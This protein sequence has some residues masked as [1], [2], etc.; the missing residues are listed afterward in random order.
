MLNN[1]SFMLI[2]VLPESLINFRGELLVALKNKIGTVFALSEPASRDV[3][4][5][6]DAKGVMHIPYKIKRNQLTLFGDL[7]VFFQFKSI[8]KEYRPSFVLAYTIKPIIWGGIAAKFTN[9]QFI[10][11]ITGLG[12]AFQGHSLSRSI[13]MQIVKILYKIALKQSKV[14]LFQ[15]RDNAEFFINSGLV[16]KSKVRIVNGSGVNLEKFSFKVAPIMST[17]KLTFLCVARLLKEK[18]LREYA[19]AAKIV[20]RK[21]PR[22]IFQ[23]LGPLDTSPDSI[24]LDEI[25]AWKNVEYLGETNDV[26]PY[27]RACHVYVLP[28]YH[29]GLPRSTLEAMSIGRPI[30][31]TNAVGCR[32][33]VIERWNGLMFDAADADQL[34]EK[35]IWCIENQDQLPLMGK[36]SRELVEAKFDVNTVN[37]QILKA[38]GL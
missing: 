35:L 3:S 15:N 30:L 36:N 25:K 27:M 37:Q 38:V 11:L 5:T 6:L 24:G 16:K 4:L 20:S 14:V 28:S 17:D 26:R 29:E 1:K 22:A 13:L 33:T 23:L 7:N 19:H 2:G 32:E 21:Y 34:A 31:T 12:Y 18:G 10:P 9:T 8:F